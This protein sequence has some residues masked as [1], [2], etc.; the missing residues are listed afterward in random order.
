MTAYCQ[1]YDSRLTAK[2]RDQLWNPT[3]G[4]RVWATFTFSACVLLQGCSFCL[5]KLYKFHRKH[6]VELRFFDRYFGELTFKLQLIYVHG[7][8]IKSLQIQRLF[9]CRSGVSERLC[10]DPRRSP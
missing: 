1:V 9:V 6:I 2:N 10:H 8:L 5:G 4:N 3:L 7:D